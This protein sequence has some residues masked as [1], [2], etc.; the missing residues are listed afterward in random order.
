MV[1]SNIIIIIISIIIIIIFIDKRRCHRISSSSGSSIVEEGFIEVKL[2]VVFF[3]TTQT[4]M[5]IVRGS[6]MMSLGTWK[7]RSTKYQR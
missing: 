2:K 7:A 3:Q 4:K 1:V 5:P 6:S